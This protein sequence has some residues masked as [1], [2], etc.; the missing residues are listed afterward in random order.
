MKHSLMLVAFFTVSAAWGQEYRATIQGSVFDPNAAVVPGAQLTLRNVDTSIER[1]TTS[2]GAGHYIFQ[3]VIAGTYS[4]TTHATGFKTD[5]HEQIRLSVADDVRL[6]VTLTIGQQAESINVSANAAGISVDTSALG[7]L[8]Q[9]EAIEDLPLKGHGTFELFKLAAGVVPWDR[10]QDT[11]LLDQTTTTGFVTNGGP[12]A[13]NDTTVDGVPDLLDLNRSVSYGSYNAVVAAYVP[14]S[15][16]MQEFKMQTSTLPAEYGHTSGS[17]MNVI[18]KSGSNAIHGSAYG[19]FRDTVM[20]ANGFF[21][22]L[23]GQPLTPSTTHLFG[24]ALGGPIYFPKIYNG[25][26]RTFFFASYEYMTNPQANQGTVS[27][28]TAQM[29]TG[30]FSQLSTQIYNPYSMNY[31]GTVPTR[32]PFP[33][34]QIPSSLIN[35]VGAAILSYMPL[36][37]VSVSGAPWQ[38]NHVDSVNY[39]FN[40]G[41]WTWKFDQTVSEKQQIFLRL[42]YGSGWLTSPATA[43]FNGIART[44]GIEDTRANRGFGFGDTYVFSP[45]VA[46]DL[47]VGV[48]RGANLEVP[49]SHGFNVATLGFPASFT[50]TLTQETDGF[51][52]IAFTDGMAPM[53]YASHFQNWCTNWSTGGAVTIVIGRHF[54]KLGDQVRVMLGDWWNNTTPDG[55]FTFRPNESG[56]PNASA[57]SGG[58]SITSLLLGFGQ[59]YVTTPSIDSWVEHYNGLYAQDDFRVTPRLTLNYGIRWEYNGNRTERY[60]RSVRGFAYNSPSSLQVPGLNLTGGLVYAGVDG[61]PRGLFDPEY[62]NFSPRVGFAYSL[63]DK[64]ALRGGYTLLYVPISSIILP[65]GYYEQTPWVSTTNGGLTVANSLSNPFPNGQ[66]PL[67]GNSQGLATLVGLAAA[68]YEPNDVIPTVHTWQINLQRALPSK[69]LLSVAYVGSRGVHLKAGNYNA[70]QVPSKDFSLGSQL[71]QQVTN[72]FYN[73]LPA[74]SSIGGSTV[75]MAQLLMPFPQFTTVTRDQPAYGNSHYE[76]AQFQYEKRS[77]NGLTG[78]VAYTI[79]KNID[80]LSSAPQNI[81]N[82]QAEREISAYDTPQRLTLAFGWDLPFGRERHFLHGTSRVADLLVGGWQL[83]TNSTFQGGQP[84]AF[85]VAGGTYFSN[86]IRPVVVGDPSQGI[87]SNI[88]SRLKGYFNTAA[89]AVPP[90]FTLGDVAPRIGS[91]RA[92]G[93]NII[94]ATLGK[95]FSIWETLKLDVRVTAYNFLNHPIFGAPGTT[96]GAASFGV[97]SSQA[98]YG[99]QMELV[100]KLVF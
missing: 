52:P 67:V 89:F 84:L 78:V 66:L 63:S 98:N 19:Y 14:S 80:D 13:T 77:A 60:N 97:V 96:I 90:N 50:N 21:G 47:R 38:N 8:V 43:D 22:N 94:N 100:A 85:S 53:G 69:G 27:V 1:K 54:I 75:Q 51:P 48:S 87:T 3:F 65:E 62:K 72:P 17:V 16:A 28:A 24:G 9:R 11:R 15:D 20:D 92:P 74:T 58:L 49:Y 91:V 42:N 12:A 71:T 46:L 76:A 79:S 10:Y 5:T 88:G 99:R 56:G 61:T 57:P 86:S 81:Y 31:V 45:K 34:N 73:I 35:P 37:N 30:N 32:T 82:R 39:P 41:M 7:T 59:G 95:R 36:P 83:S 70:D 2:D 40:Y 68:Y 18:V 6:D 26:D 55:N 33:N 25:K 64:W 23:A 29:R 93:M 44:S 4:L